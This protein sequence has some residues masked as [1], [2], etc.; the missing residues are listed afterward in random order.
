MACYQSLVLG[1]SKEPR[2][3]VW[4]QELKSQSLINLLTHMGFCADPSVQRELVI[5]AHGHSGLAKPPE[6]TVWR[7]AKEKECRIPNGAP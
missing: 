4:S 6:T 5:K 1:C 2:G 7:A 3:L